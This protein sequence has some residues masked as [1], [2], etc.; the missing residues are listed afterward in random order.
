MFVK[1][2]RLMVVK[3]ETKSHGIIRGMVGSSRDIVRLLQALT[4]DGKTCIRW[5]VENVD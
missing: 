2:E 1:G 4:A 3:I 5:S